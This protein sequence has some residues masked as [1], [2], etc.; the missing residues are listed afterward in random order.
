[1]VQLTVLL[2]LFGDCH[3]LGLVHG[4]LL[5]ELRMQHT[6]TIIYL[7]IPVDSSSIQY[8]IEK[9]LNYVIFETEYQLNKNIEMKIN[10][11]YTEYAM[12]KL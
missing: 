5:E 7:Q 1:M 8:L 2:T 9:N 3:V 6:N 10:I 4:Q 11:T 12:N